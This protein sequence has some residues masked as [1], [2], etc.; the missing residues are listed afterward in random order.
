LIIGQAPGLKAHESGVS[1]N[2]AS[3]DRLRFW[4]EMDRNQFYDESKVAIIPMGF[5]FLGTDKTGGDLPPFKGCAPFWHPQ[6]LPLFP[7]IQLTLLVGS[8]AQKF[9]LKELCKGSLTETVLAFEEYL[10]QFFCLP[11]PSWRNTGW[12]KRHLW[13]EERVLP[14]LRSMVHKILL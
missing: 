9:Y 6:L 11:H 3:G 8:F 2:D 12:I 7:N 14:R 5:C 13:F 10:P 1:F 4:L